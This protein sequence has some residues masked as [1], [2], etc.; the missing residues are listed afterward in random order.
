M[1][2]PLFGFLILAA[3]CSAAPAPILSTS[4]VD[5]VKNRDD[6]TARSLIKQHADVNAAEPDGSTP[7][8]WAAHWNN[9]ELA[10]LLLKSGADVKAVNRYGLTPLAEAASTGSGAL[11][12]RLLQAGSDANTLST[13]QGETVLMTAARVGNVD[14]VKALLAHGADADA[15]ENYRGQTAVMWAAAEGHPE[16]IKLLAAHG[17]NL[18]VRSIDRDTIAPKMEAGTPSAPIARGGMTALQYAARQGEMESTRALLDAG[19]DI[20]QKDSDGNTALVLAILNNH[21][22]VAQFLIDRN[23]DLN[24]GNKDGRAALYT[25]VDVHDADWSPRPARRESDQHTSLEIVQALLAKDAKV[26]AQ[27]TAASPIIRL[28]QDT[29]D[30]TMASGATPFLRAARSADVEVMR[31]LIAKGANPKLANKDGLTALMVA[32]GVSWSDKIRGTEAEALEAVKLS[33]DLSLDVNAATDKGDTALHGAALRGAD[34]IVKY[35]A[36]HGAKLDVKNK[37]GLTPLDLAMGKV[38]GPGATPRPP[39]ES[40]VALLNQLIQAQPPQ[41]ESAEA[42]PAPAPPPPQPEQP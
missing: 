40:T 36:D 31:L 19:A 33:G 38:A 14:G 11:I 23:A 42:T 13:K 5:A 7:L 15:R 8:L 18:S 24:I 34:S 26:D 41:A 39:K 2:I 4:L 35:L 30:R 12:E 29:G 27:L 17:A 3:I 10:D 25:A 1:R 32:A 28:A 16:V 21:Y 37:Q 9:L 22:D 6:A 20:N